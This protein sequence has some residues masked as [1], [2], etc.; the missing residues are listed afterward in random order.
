MQHVNGGHRRGWLTG[1][2]TLRSSTIHK[3][4]RESGQPHLIVRVAFESA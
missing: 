4:I 1:V 3:R 2:T